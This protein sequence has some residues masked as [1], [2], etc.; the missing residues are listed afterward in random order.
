MKLKT[1]NQWRKS[2]KLRADSLKINKID[3][4]DTR[5]H[6][7]NETGYINTGPADIKKIVRE[8]YQ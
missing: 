1:E 3:R 4:E 2:M 6:I 7:G 5:Y 8:Y